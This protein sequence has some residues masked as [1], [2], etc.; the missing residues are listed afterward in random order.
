MD[1]E[2]VLWHIFSRC[3]FEIEVS[4]YLQYVIKTLTNAKGKQKDWNVD[5]VLGIQ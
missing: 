1:C 4:Y 5:L 3:W 2:S